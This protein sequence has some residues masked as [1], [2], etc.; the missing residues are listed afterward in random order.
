MK[1]TYIVTLTDEER[2][3][4][5]EMLSRG[6]AAAR[7][8]S[9]VGPAAQ[10]V[11]PSLVAS[12]GDEEWQVRRPAAEALA[13]IGPPSAPAVPALIEALGDEPRGTRHEKRDTTLK[14]R[15]TGHEIRTRT[16]YRF[17][18]TASSPRRSRRRMEPARANA[19]LNNS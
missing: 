19:L 3:M 6:K 5:Q 12:L 7:A 16:G 15:A 4:L 2:Q 11:V 18:T 1:K 17:L 10:Q 8:L 9:R 14:P 13:A